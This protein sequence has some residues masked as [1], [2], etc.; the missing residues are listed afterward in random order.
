LLC[1]LNWFSA[2]I[3]SERAR[4]WRASRKP[5][6]SEVEGDPYPKDVAGVG[7]LRLARAKAAPHSLSMTANMGTFTMKLL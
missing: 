5:A 2:V 7:V 3:L 4:L 1:N 6:L